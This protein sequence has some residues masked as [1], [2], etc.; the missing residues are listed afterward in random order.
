MALRA[1]EATSLVTWYQCL[2]CPPV[3]GIARRLSHHGLPDPRSDDKAP[4]TWQN[5]TLVVRVVSL[6]ESRKLT[7]CAERSRVHSR[8]KSASEGRRAATFFLP[9][10]GIERFVTQLYTVN[11][12]T[13][14][15]TNPVS[16]GGQG[17]NQAFG[18]SFFTESVTSS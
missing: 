10:C 7:R 12:T 5:G 17:L 6:V 1:Y 9:S 3:S 16:F 2:Q 13:G 11:T 18:E 4:G 14:A 15:A 8:A